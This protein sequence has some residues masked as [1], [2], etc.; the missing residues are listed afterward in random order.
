LA[1][2]VTDGSQLITGHVLL[3]GV[4]T[5]A[6]SSCELGRPRGPFDSTHLHAPPRP[7]YAPPAPV[8]IAAS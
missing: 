1:Q 5:P 3:A 4:V 6:G 2:V 7:F 8:R